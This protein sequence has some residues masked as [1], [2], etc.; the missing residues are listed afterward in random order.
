M[1]AMNIMGAGGSIY[2]TDDT[3]G[4]LEFFCFVIPNMP[5]HLAT[6]TAITHTWPR[7][8]MQL[9]QNNSTAARQH[10]N[11]AA[12]QAQQHSK[13]SSTAAQHAARFPHLVISSF[14]LHDPHFLCGLFCSRAGLLEK[15]SYE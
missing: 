6:G 7:Q 5:H 9:Q 11:T 1:H 12:Q 14:A 15:T 13:H 2:G 8:S 10:G 3:I 4:H